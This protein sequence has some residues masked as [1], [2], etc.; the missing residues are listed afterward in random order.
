M[1][2]TVFVWS[3]LALLTMAL[4]LGP[5]FAH[6]LEAPPR[7]TVWTP[8]LWREAT[9]L[10]GQFAY[11]AIIGAPLD[12]GSVLLGAV[13]AIVIRHRRPA[14]WLAMAATVLFATS[15]ATWFAVVAPMNA[16][17]AHW[18]PGPIP[19]NFE[20]VRNRWEAGHIVISAIKVVGLSC[21]I[22]GVLSL[23]TRRGPALRASR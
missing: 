7:L 16:I 19:D 17:L 10:N 15:L 18:G 1:S 2:R 6:L 9:V 4:S 3:F 20:A 21:M 11:F 5:S 13:V 22:A 8:E 14:F 12:V 23:G